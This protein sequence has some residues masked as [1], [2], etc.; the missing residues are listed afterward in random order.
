[1]FVDK[2]HHRKGIARQLYDTV[3]SEINKNADVAQVTVNSSPYAVNVYERLGFAKTDEQQEHENGIVYVPMAHT[4]IET[5]T[6]RR[7]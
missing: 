7:L 4:T 6:P 5:N 3:L 1:M 2:K